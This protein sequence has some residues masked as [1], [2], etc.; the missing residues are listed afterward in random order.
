[1]NELKNL[2]INDYNELKNILYFYSNIVIDSNKN[3][4]NSK[5]NFSKIYNKI[6]DRKF[7]FNEDFLLT[8][9]DLYFIYD[10]KKEN[11]IYTNLNNINKKILSKKL[12]ESEKSYF[13]FFLKKVIIS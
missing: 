10:F 7:N 5:I 9:N 3:D 4:I 8:L 12:S 2:N 1:M 11:N 13:I 6:E